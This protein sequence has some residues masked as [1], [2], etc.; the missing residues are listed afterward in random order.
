FLFRVCRA[1][2][3]WTMENFIGRE[4]ERIRADV[5]GAGVLC[6]L[7]GGVDSAVTAAIVDRAVGDRLTG[8]FVDNG[9]LRANEA[10]Q[11]R[12]GFRAS[13]PRTRCASSAVCS[14]S[15]TRF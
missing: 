3:T 14:T 15:P 1:E 10:D 12:G 5:D 2:P 13:S 8:V 9:V 11:V 6:A 7:S 4:V